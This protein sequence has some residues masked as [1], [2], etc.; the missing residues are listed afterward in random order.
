MNQK[1]VATNGTNAIESLIE[2]TR[3]GYPVVPL[4]T[5][6]KF[7]DKPNRLM[8]PNSELAGNS[9]N[10]PPLSQAE[11]FSTTIFWDVN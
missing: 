4:P 3:T 2:Y 8:Y 10:V 7:P 5:S 11:A 6:A 1:C 9:S